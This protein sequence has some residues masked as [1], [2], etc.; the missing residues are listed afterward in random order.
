MKILLKL[1]L[2]LT[3]AFSVSVS[4]IYNSNP[5]DKEL[6]NL[7][8]FKPDETLSIA[9]GNLQ[10]AELA[11]DINKQLISYYYII[12]SLSIMSRHDEMQQYTDKALAI[13]RANNNI[14]FQSEFISYQAY[15]DEIRGDYQSA[16]SHVNKALQLA[17]ETED[18]KLIASQTS[19][20]GQIHLAM[21]NYDLA[22][23]DVESSIEVF[24]NNDDKKNLSLAYNLL[25][26]IYIAMQD[27]D[28]AIKYYRESEKF[29]EVKSPFN[30]AVFHYNLGGT[31]VMLEDYEKA[32]ENYNKSSEFSR[33]VNDET[34]LAFNQYGIAEV[35]VATKEFK[36]AEEILPPVIELFAKN[37]DILMHFNSNLLMSEIKIENKDFAAAENYLKYAEE[38]AN[39]IQTPSTQLYLNWYKIKFYTSQEMWKEAY[40]LEKQSTKIRKEVQEK[41][42]EKLVSEL[43]IKFNAQF[44]QEKLE[45]LQKQNE[46]Q[47]TAL[48][49][50]K[51]KQK[52]L[53]GLVI[54]G[55]I[56]FFIIL[57]AYFLQLKT[58]KHLY[59]LSI[60]DHLTKVANRRHIMNTLQALLIKSRNY[61]STLAVI[62]I[63]LDYFK[64][65]NDTYGHDI[66]NE[67]L[68][69]FANTACHLIPEKGMV[70]RIGGE[71]WLMLIPET[72]VKLVNRFMSELRERYQRPVPAPIPS[73]IVLTFSSGIVLSDGQ[74][75]KYDNLL[76]DVD[77]AMYRAKNRGRE[78][79][80]FVGTKVVNN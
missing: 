15:I 80:V 62:L 58:K 37:G 57:F 72:D 26:I 43:R 76:K 30:Q 46:L 78:Q 74:Y 77:N 1:T 29:D 9:L 68:V 69:H 31:Y 60:T 54:L 73:N 2:L 27:Y 45:L 28:N 41:D 70:G 65:I 23:K 17:L 11:G 25:A 56:L 4:A 55:V 22:M 8:L 47:Q 16:S 33:K 42:K 53:W 36:K 63:D 38:Q 14:V 21:E 34:T 20:R 49:Q 10:K 7:L 39:V 79:D 3:L 59:K 75:E 6:E 61:N 13:A 35:Y 71:E 32:I 48:T 40:E 67:V 51:T 19:M 64:T 66:G 5:Y 12:E 50:E 24:K 18:V 44:D 52:Y